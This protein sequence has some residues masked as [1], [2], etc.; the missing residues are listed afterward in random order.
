M[1][2]DPSGDRRNSQSM[3]TCGGFSSLDADEINMR[4]RNGQEINGKVVETKRF[5]GF[6]I[7][8]VGNVQQLQKLRSFYYIS[9]SFKDTPLVHETSMRRVPCGLYQNSKLYTGTMNK[10]QR[11]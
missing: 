3:F 2:L 4:V 8:I 1:Q 10:T 7:Q 9:P 11:G 6:Q 5:I